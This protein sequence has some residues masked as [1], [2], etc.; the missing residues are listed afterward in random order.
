MKAN[1]LL[2][3]INLNDMNVENHSIHIKDKD[4]L[5]I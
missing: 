2:Q 1:S 4:P 5:G 3:G